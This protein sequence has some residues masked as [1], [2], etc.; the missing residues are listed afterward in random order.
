MNNNAVPA[1]RLPRLRAHLAGQLA[2]HTV[3]PTQARFS[4]DGRLLVTGAEDDAGRRLEIGVW[5]VAQRSLMRLLDTPGYSPTFAP[6]GQ[7]IAFG[8]PTGGRVVFTDL[9]GA[10]VGELSG[11]ARNAVGIVFSPD[12]MLLATGDSAG[13]VRLWDVASRTLRAT[14]QAQ[15]Q[16]AAGLIAYGEPKSFSADGRW[17]LVDAPDQLGAAQLYEIT[18]GEDSSV[19]VEWRAALGAA[20]ASLSAG[21]FSPRGRLLALATDRD[22]GLLLV[23][24][25]SFE[26]ARLPALADDQHDTTRALAFS[27]DNLWLAELTTAHG[28]VALWGILTG[29]LALA[30]EAHTDYYH[31]LGGDPLTA[32][33]DIAW[34]RDG[35][36][37]ATA[38]MAAMQTT[39]ATTA[40]A[41]ARRAA[42]V[43]RLWETERDPP[44][45]PLAPLP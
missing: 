20:R 22:A 10:V 8:T 45:P 24:L 36:T 6:D 15:R 13:Q 41:S 34:S 19:E 31:T 14:F 37:I 21:V 38:G 1:L 32:A 17:L 25:P 7:T 29:E 23:R 28:Q 3:P 39:D 43:I 30:W 40:G 26:R 18:R 4:P 2:G 33:Y 44:W 9:L 12:G 16:P 5:D 11:H 27:P 42:P 35:R